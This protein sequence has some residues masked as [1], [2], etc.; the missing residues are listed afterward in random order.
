MNYTSVQNDDFCST[1]YKI[2]QLYEYCP[3]DLKREIS[4]RAK[5]KRNFAEQELLNIIKGVVSVLR[6]LKEKGLSHHDVRPYTILI[7]NEGVLKLSENLVYPKQLSGYQQLCME[8]IQDVYLA[9]KLLASLKE[10]ELSPNGVDVDK[11]D[12]FS[13]GMTVL[14]AATL[15]SV[16]G[17]YN[18]QEY[19][20]SPF[21]LD[22]MLKIV[23]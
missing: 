7:S 16:A 10:R 3:N 11:S 1:F 22:L 18:M 23:E 20:V 8:L 6:F 19:I 17:V 4:E 21:A 15:Q 2:S 5:N 12:V 13:L 9:P 14:E